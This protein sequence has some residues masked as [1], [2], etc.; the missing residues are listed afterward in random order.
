MRGERVREN[1]RERGR[2]R[3]CVRVRGRED[4]RVGEENE[5]E[6]EEKTQIFS[7]FPLQIG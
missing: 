4:D 1:G 3:E 7:S 2:G 6:G 5:R